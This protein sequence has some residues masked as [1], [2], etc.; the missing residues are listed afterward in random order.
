MIIT[1][2][3]IF[4][5][6]IDF[7]N[8]YIIDKNTRNFN[9]RIPVNTST[10]VFDGKKYD[11]LYI[12]EPRV[13]YLIPLSNKYQNNESYILKNLIGESGII[14]QLLEKYILLYNAS[15]NLIFLNKGIEICNINEVQKWQF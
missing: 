8:I 14:L 5:I 1:L 15:E 3:K 11:T 2:D 6:D 13:V 4:Q 9:K 12:I 10:R 7:E